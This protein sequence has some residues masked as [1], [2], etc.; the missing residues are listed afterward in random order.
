MSDAE[1]NAGQAARL[2]RLRNFPHRKSDRLFAEDVLARAGHGLDLPAVL[3]MRRCQDHEIDRNVPEDA[4][5]IRGKGHIEIVRMR[6]MLLAASDRIHDANDIGADH[7]PQD[8]LAPPSK[9]DDGRVY[10]TG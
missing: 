2:E 5:E 6:P 7:L 8:V 9:S 3:G 4:R 1:A 10:G